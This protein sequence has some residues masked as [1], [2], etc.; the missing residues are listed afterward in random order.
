MAA[1]Y[2]LLQRESVYE[3]YEKLPELFNIEVRRSSSP[4]VINL[5]INVTNRANNVTVMCGNVNVSS[6]PQFHTLFSLI[7]EFI[8]KFINQA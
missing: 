4:T 7:L 6:G 8:G 1:V 2:R 5:H 3:S